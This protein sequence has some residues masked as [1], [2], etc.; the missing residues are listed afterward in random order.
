M[1]CISATT[2]PL[3]R[4]ALSPRRALDARNDEPRRVAYRSAQVVGQTSTA[5]DDVTFAWFGRLLMDIVSTGNADHPRLTRSRSTGFSVLRTDWDLAPYV[6]ETAYE[7][8]G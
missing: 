4:V 6:G 3:G 7:Q 8:S 2:G 5:L 1:Q